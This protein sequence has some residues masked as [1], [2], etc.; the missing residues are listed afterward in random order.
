MV[1]KL[2]QQHFLEACDEYARRLRSYTTVE[3]QSVKREPVRGSLSTAE[4]EQ[5]IEQEG[6]RIIDQLD[7]T[8]VNF[9]LDARGKQLSSRALAKRL[10][11]LRVNGKTDWTFVIG[12]PLG[13]SRAVLEQVRFILSLSKLT[14][15]HELVPVLILEQVYRSFKI[16]RGEPYHR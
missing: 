1:G 5:V 6:T 16:I 15:P 12:G 4:K 11:S 10:N 2:K 3:L 14:F 7:D 13:L 9:A 8:H